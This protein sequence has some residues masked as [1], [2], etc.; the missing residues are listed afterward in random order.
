MAIAAAA[1][2]AGTLLSAYSSYKAGKAAEKAS[3]KQQSLLN[4]QAEEVFARAQFNDDLLQ[5]QGNQFVGA[6]RVAIAGSGIDIGT[7]SSLDIIE[8]TIRDINDERLRQ[9]R[10][11]T[12]EANMIAEGAV[13]EGEYAKDAATA[14]MIGGAGTLLTSGYKLSQT[15]LFDFKP[16]YESLPAFGTPTSYA[17]VDAFS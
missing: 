1:A 4:R 15:D 7:G 11:S 2:I 6:Q 5:K 16:G 12:F 13:L 9:L 10:D 8:D 3:I 14:G 17:G